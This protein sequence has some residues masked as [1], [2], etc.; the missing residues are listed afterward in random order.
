MATTPRAVY[1]LLRDGQV[2]LW[3]KLPEG[4]FDYWLVTVHSI[5]D[6]MMVRAKRQ[7]FYAGTN[8]PYERGVEPIKRMPNIPAEV[9]KVLDAAQ[10]QA[11]SETR[12]PELHPALCQAD[13]YAGDPPTPTS[14]T[15][16]ATDHLPEG[17]H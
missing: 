11:E 2:I 12:C 13:G 6:F 5:H 15:S 9:W 14:P 17:S 8:I 16:F 10:Q 1:E 7:M 3:P 4:A